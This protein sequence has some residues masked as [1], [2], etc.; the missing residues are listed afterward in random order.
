MKIRGQ[1]GLYLEN[2]SFEGSLPTE[3]AIFP[4]LDRYSLYKQTNIFL[5]NRTERNNSRTADK[6][7]EMQTKSEQADITGLNKQH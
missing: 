1:G 4:Q 3:M 7:A 2:H 5:L 6:R